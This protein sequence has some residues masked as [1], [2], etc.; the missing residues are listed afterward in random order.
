MMVNTAILSGKVVST[1]LVVTQVTTKGKLNTVKKADGLACTSTDTG[2]VGVAG[3]QNAAVL[4]GDETHGALAFVN[5]S[6]G[7]YRVAQRFQVWYPTIPLKL[8]LR[9]ATPLYKIKGWLEPPSCGKQAVQKYQSTPYH[10]VATFTSDGKPAQGFSADVTQLVKAYSTS[11]SVA[12]V[13]Y[14]DATAAV[15]GVSPGTAKLDATGHAGK[16]LG[17]VNIT[18]SP[19]GVGI[20]SFHAVAVKDFTVSAAATQHFNGSHTATTVCAKPK[21]SPVVLTYEKEQTQIVAFVRFTDGTE[22]HIEDKSRLRL[23]ALD[24]GSAVVADSV[25]AAVPVSGVSSPFSPKIN[26]S[27]LPKCSQTPLRQAQAWFAVKLPLPSA[28]KVS[29]TANIELAPPDDAAA[30]NGL[31]SKHA[32]KVQLVWAQPSRTVDFTGDTRT[33]VDVSHTGGGA[34]KITVEHST[35]GQGSLVLAV[36]KGATA[37]VVSVKVYFAHV[38]LTTAFKVTI[39][40]HLKFQVPLSPYPVY[41]GSSSL[42][43]DATTPLK[44]IKC[45]QPQRFEMAQAACYMVLS[46]GRRIGTNLATSKAVVTLDNPG[47]AAISIKGTVITPSGEG[48]VHVNCAFGGAK[49][50]K[51]DRAELAVGGRSSYVFVTEI[52]KFRLKQGSDLLDGAK[53]LRGKAGRD[54]AVSVVS[55]KLSDGRLYEDLTSPFTQAAG[56]PGLLK[57][58][59]DTDSAAVINATTGEVSLVGNGYRPVTFSVSVRGL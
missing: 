4:K 7:G 52:S 13:T 31:R 47:N 49:T 20:C 34:P 35:G 19:T 10:A 32:I 22:M 36:V 21:D 3:E 37:G 48:T 11:A 14:N 5:C 54:G 28:M 38:N 55:V 33:K 12:R 59:S 25:F 1:P 57:F 45:T 2:V 46:T 39:S 17:T 9:K 51:T 29:P 58:T 41:A 16:P 50:P 43:I 42:A 53:S 18:V 8:A 44:P 40:K 56:L 27:L 30:Q 6:Y 15:E 24:S 23:H 26:V